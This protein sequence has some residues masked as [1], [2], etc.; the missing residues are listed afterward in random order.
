MVLLIYHT[1]KGKKI[2]KISI[3]Q[4]TM[5]RR[6]N[7]L[8]TSV[9]NTKPGASSFKCLSLALDEV[10]DVSDAAHLETFADGVDKN[11]NITEE[12]ASL[13]TLKGHQNKTPSDLPEG[14][15]AISER[16]GLNLTYWSGVTTDC[17]PAMEGR[18]EGL[19]K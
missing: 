17:V 8:A 18:K 3:S 19:A 15:M 9:E 12:V 13:L 16:L 4:Q 14:V 1:L 10:T 11:F 2:T 6:L 5:A 7:D